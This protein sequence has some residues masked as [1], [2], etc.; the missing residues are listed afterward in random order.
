MTV[1][2]LGA[3]TGYFEPL[4]SRGVGATGTVLA[5]DLEPDMV[6]YLGERAAREHLANVRP[7]L[8]TTDDPKLAPMSVDRILDAVDSL[9]WEDQ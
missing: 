1:A 3:G 4:L 7:G 2:D 8:V 6:R 9:Q 5:L